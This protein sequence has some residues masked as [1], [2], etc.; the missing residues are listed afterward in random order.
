MTAVDYAEGQL[1]QML[2][3]DDRVAEQGLRVVR[4]DDGLSVCGEVESAAR[5]DLIERLVAE[6]FPGLR[7]RYDIGIT[8]VHEP[9]D[10]EEL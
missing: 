9:D 6:T 2:T 1:Q 3:E 4:M 10:V 7:V 8:R 5:R